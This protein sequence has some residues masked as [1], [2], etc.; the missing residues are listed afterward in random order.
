MEAKQQFSLYFQLH[1]HFIL[2][3]NNL[4]S[5]YKLYC[6]NICANNI[7]NLLYIMPWNPRGAPI[8][9]ATFNKLVIESIRISKKLSVDVSCQ[10]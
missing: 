1:K 10:V 7:I 5:T 3:V 9:T 8:F 6:Y 4:F 2:L